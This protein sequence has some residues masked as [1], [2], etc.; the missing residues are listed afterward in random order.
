MFVQRLSPWAAGIVGQRRLS[1]P[2]P[3]PLAPPMLCPKALPSLPLSP[4]ATAGSAM[5][6]GPGQI[7][8]ASGPVL[9]QAS[10]LVLRPTGGPVLGPTGM[11]ETDGLGLLQPQGGVGAPPAAGGRLGALAGKGRVSGRRGGAGG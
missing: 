6:S 7:F 5:A 8:P 3:R 11:A 4:E 9:G 1:L 2:E 10:S